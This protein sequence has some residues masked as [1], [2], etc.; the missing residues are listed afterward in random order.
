[1]S[2]AKA[3]ASAV[4]VANNVMRH[5]STITSDGGLPNIVM[6]HAS[7]LK[8]LIASHDALQ[9]TAVEA[10]AT[11][12]V[13]ISALEFTRPRA[14]QVVISKDRAERLRDKLRAAIATATA[15]TPPARDA[16]IQECEIDGVGK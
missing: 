6:M 3:Q 14:G 9:Q 13:A 16:L 10:L 15:T 12:D 2:D 1:V 11:Y 5:L 8:V 7:D 4:E